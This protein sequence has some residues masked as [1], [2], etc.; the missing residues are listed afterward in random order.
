MQNSASKDS[1]RIVLESNSHVDH[2]WRANTWVP[3][4]NK[5]SPNQIIKGM[6]FNFIPKTYVWLNYI[7]VALRVFGFDR[8]KF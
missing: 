5:S 1:R 8:L 6:L 3:H 4:E 7:K 2:R